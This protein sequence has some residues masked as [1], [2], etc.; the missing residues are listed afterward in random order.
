MLTSRG[1][2]FAKLS[3]GFNEQVLSRPARLGE[4]DRSRM[5]LCHTDL[6][7]SGG[8]R[9]SVLENVAHAPIG[10]YATVSMQILGRSK[11]AMRRV[12]SPEVGTQWS[13]PWTELRRTAG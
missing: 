12:H 10:D 6:R 3:R 13:M 9:I 2:P 11:R 7:I 8:L 5:A 4:S 1:R